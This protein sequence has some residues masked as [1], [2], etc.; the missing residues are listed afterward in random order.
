M[1][2]TKWN[3]MEL[4]VG[5]YNGFA[6]QNFASPSSGN[7]PTLAPTKSKTY[8]ITWNLNNGTLAGKNKLASYTYGKGFTLKNPTRKGYE[9]SGWYSDK[10]FMKR[11]KSIGKKQTGNI[12][13]Y[14]KWKKK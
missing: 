8:M 6:T 4:G 12:T 1:L 14:A 11:V 7:E 3:G 9:F 10:K 2:N 5:Y 13:L